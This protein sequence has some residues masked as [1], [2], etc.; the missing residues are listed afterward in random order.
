[1][2]TKP[3]LLQTAALA[4]ANA[5]PDRFMRRPEVERITGKSCS[6][7]YRDMAEGRFPKAVKIGRGPTASVAWLASEI[8]AWQR[9]R[10]EE[11]R[12]AA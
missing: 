2:T 8:A 10:V 11:S 7:I 6:A 9:A 12:A 1:M 4:P 5:E 3:H